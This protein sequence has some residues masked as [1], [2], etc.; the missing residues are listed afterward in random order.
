[1]SRALVAWLRDSGRPSILAIVC[2]T[3]LAATIAGASAGFLVDEGSTLDSV[4][5]VLHQAPPPSE[6]TPSTVGAGSSEF[7]APSQ[8]TTEPSAYVC[9]TPNV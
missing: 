6:P 3:I 1:M 2:P 9:R 8:L 5:A 4:S 7:S